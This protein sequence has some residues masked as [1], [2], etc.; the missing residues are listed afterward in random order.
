M[1]YSGLEMK[2]HPRFEKM[3]E[4]GQTITSLDVAH[5][6]SKAIRLHPLALTAFILSLVGIPV[7]GLMTG[8]IA[9]ILAGIALGQ[10]TENPLLRGRG[11]AVAALA[12]GLVD[13]VLWVV[14][15]GFVVPRIN[16]PA[17]RA[18]EQSIVP[19]SANVEMAPGHIRARP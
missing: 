8:A 17:G 5:F 18:I 19:S 9:M 15:L 16:Q 1:W 12:I 14:M 10:L 2:E 11:L 7:V 3:P 13:I 6:S 4:I